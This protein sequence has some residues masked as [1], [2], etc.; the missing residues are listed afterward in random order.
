[1]NSELLGVVQLFSLLNYYWVIDNKFGDYN[2]F[3]GTLYI[4]WG[5]GVAI[6]ISGIITNP[7]SVFQIHQQEHIIHTQSKKEAFN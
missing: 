3:L 4:I 5:F 1:M 6:T 2:T 7:N